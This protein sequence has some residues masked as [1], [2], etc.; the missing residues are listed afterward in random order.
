MTVEERL[1]EA[2]QRLIYRCPVHPRNKELLAAERLKISFSSVAREAGVSRTLIGFKDAAYLR[3]RKQIAD[4]VELRR[5]ARNVLL[6]SNASGIKRRNKVA[7]ANHLAAEEILR[8]WFLKNSRNP[9]G[10]TIVPKKTA[11]QRMAELS[12]VSKAPRLV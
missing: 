11:K 3:I 2:L 5:D 8:L 6:A 12:L 1:Q 4:L 9:D 7:E 10:S